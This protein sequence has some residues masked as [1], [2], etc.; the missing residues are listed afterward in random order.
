MKTMLAPLR[1][2]MSMGAVLEEAQAH[3]APDQTPIGR[4]AATRGQAQLPAEV[5]RKVEGWGH[6]LVRTHPVT[7]EKALY[8]DQTYTAGIDGLTPEEAA[9]LLQFLVRHITQPAFTC[10][11]RWEA[12]TFALWDNRICVHQAFNDTDGFRRE[13]YRTTVA[14]EAPV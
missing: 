11:L 5:V 3:Q 6:P 7:G 10:R 2:R 12:G 13:M 9:P 4:L 14:G 1:V 8:C